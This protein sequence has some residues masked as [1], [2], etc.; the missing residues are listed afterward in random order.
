M[1][2]RHCQIYRDPEITL[3]PQNPLSESLLKDLFHETNVVYVSRPSL[4]TM[5]P[6]LRQGWNILRVKAPQSKTDRFKKFTSIENY[7]QFEGR[8]GY[9]EN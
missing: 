4:K 2:Y 8:V 5:K 9:K 7:T 6:D 3:S 1:G